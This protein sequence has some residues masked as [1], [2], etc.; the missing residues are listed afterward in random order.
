MPK[1]IIAILYNKSKYNNGIIVIFIQIFISRKKVILKML[2]EYYLLTLTL[3]IGIESQN[4][5]HY[6]FT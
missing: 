6:I 2:F 3:N 4:I 1:Q 5:F